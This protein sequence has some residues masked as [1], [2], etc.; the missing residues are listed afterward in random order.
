M[1]GT[2]TGAVP[3]APELPASANLPVLSS[4]EPFGKVEEI[5]GPLFSGAPAG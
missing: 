4:L 3:K 5:C 2:Y 1:P